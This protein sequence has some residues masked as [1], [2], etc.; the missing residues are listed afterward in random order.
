AEPRQMRRT[1]VALTGSASYRT[2][3]LPAA[4]LSKAAVLGYLSVRHRDTYMPSARSAGRRFAQ[5]PPPPEQRSMIRVAPI[6]F[7]A[8]ASRGTRPEYVLVWRRAVTR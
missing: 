6:L 8:A 5:G 2:P 1:S 3:G 7:R 4:S